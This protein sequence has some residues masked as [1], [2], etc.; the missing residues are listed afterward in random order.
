[1]HAG[2]L[3]IRQDGAETLTGVMSEVEPEAT[4]AAGGVSITV[5][6]ML[7]MRGAVGIESS[8][9]GAGNGGMVVVNANEL[10][11]DGEGVNI[12]Y[13][14]A[15]FI[16]GI[17]T[18]V[19]PNASGN[20]GNLS[21]TVTN[22][23]SVLN[24]GSLSSSTVGSGNAGV[25]TVRAGNLSLDG[26][27]AFLG[28]AAGIGSTGQAGDMIVAVDGLLEVLNGALILSGTFSDSNSGSLFISAKNARIGG[29]HSFGYCS[30]ITSNA[31]PGSNGN[32]GTIN[33]TL[34]GLL[35]VFDGAA[36]T[37]FS[38]G[39]GNAG[40]INV[41]V[42]NL[43]VDGTEKPDWFTG[44][45]SAAYPGST[46]QAGS[47]NLTINRSIEV[48]NGAAIGTSTYSVGNAGS[49]VVKSKSMRLDAD[50][51]LS[52]LIGIGS[53][54]E[55]GSN[56]N[57]GTVSLDIDG[58]LEILNGAEISSSIFGGTGNAG[59][60]TVQA[61]EL[62][63]DGQFSAVM[64]S[65]NIGSAGNAGA[66]NLNVNGLLKVFNGAKISTSTWSTGEAGDVLIIAKEAQLDGGGATDS[67]TTIYS[68]AYSTSI[69][70]AGTVTLN[71]DGL[72]EVRNGA[73]I[74]TN[75]W[76][77]GDAGTVT[78]HVGDL[79]LDGTNSLISS[80]AL[81]SATGN[82]GNINVIADELTINN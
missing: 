9:F 45:N 23:L 66:V 19:T 70:N 54:A 3:T 31:Y 59:T 1:V 10:L 7:E 79:L 77:V 57:A 73:A 42:E 34:S 61:D 75:A 58:L 60:V 11:M 22:T 13:R 44:M 33:L 4:G 52:H 18:E 53:T 65:A 28:T 82:V 56:G 17:A 78:L 46:G 72:L 39:A 24:S 50:G 74:S 62:R 38:M 12:F 36:I 47:I 14:G 64:S 5:D 69:G 48:L 20:A 81:E 37:T 49:I 21:V 71:I 41:M 29:C 2:D 6:G 67:I 40:T 55:F 8:T 25:F 51:N 15:E 16:A 30:G 80:R 26:V 68:D 32:A 27:Q 43:R 35:E 76:A 63:L